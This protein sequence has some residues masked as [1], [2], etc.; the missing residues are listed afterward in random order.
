MAGEL[1]LTAAQIAACYPMNAEILDVIVTEAVAAGE[2][3]YQLTT[4]KFG[5][6]DANAGGKQQFRGIAL[7]AAAAN[8]VVPMLKRGHVFGFAVSAVN[9]DS[10]LF[11]SDTAG[12]IATSAGTL[13]VN[14]GRVTALTDGSGTRI[15][16][17][18]A[19]WLR[20]WA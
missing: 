3:L 16:Y 9:A 20:T 2:A 1:T 4:G 13:S 10:A 6:A 5:V 17:I 15:V 14:V 7:R 8:Q 12:D 11:L 19:D 18:E